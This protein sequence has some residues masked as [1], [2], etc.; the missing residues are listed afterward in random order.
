MLKARVGFNRKTRIF[1]THMHGDHSLGLPGVMMTMSLLGRDR[2]LQIYG[3]PGLAAFVNAVQ[4]TIRFGVTY[5]VE[6]YEIKNEC[7]VCKGRGYTIEARYTDHKGVSLGYA[8]IEEP[9]PGVFYPEKAKALDVPE[10]PLWSKL[11]HGFSVSLP[12]GRTVM[13]LQVTGSKRP[14]R[15][16]VYT[17]DTRPSRSILNLAKDADLLIHDGTLDDSLE[18]MA[19]LEGHSTPSQ[20]AKIAKEA[21]VKRLILTHISARYKSTELLLEQARKIFPNADV[22]EDLMRVKIPLRAS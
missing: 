18:E 1:I 6:V 9:R 8:L 7:G 20:A 22:A 11:Q 10:G 4:E 12:N 21:G 15:K 5:P 3:P 19:K 17:G 13:P 2:R 14:G 16:V